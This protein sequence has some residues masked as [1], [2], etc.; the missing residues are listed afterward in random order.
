MLIRCKKCLLTYN[1][2]KFLIILIKI[3]HS[4]LN[5]PIEDIYKNFNF[6]CSKDMV[7]F[8]KSIDVILNQ[9]NTRILGKPNIEKLSQSKMLEIKFAQD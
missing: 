2:F 7:E 3:T 1:T 5:K 8:L 9:D 4:L 6:D